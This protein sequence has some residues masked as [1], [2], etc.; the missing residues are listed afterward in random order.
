MGRQQD[1]E[2]NENGSDICGR[3][4][5]CSYAKLDREVAIP[6][7]Q[8]SRCQA[9]YIWCNSCVSATCIQQTARISLMTVCT[10]SQMNTTRCKHVD[11]RL[12]LHFTSYQNKTITSARLTVVPCAM[13]LLGLNALFP[14]NVCFIR[15]ALIL[16]TH[17]KITVQQLIIS[18]QCT[19]SY[20]LSCYSFQLLVTWWSGGYDIGLVTFGR[21]F[22]SQPG[23]F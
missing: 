16:V 3:P 1:W 17:S 18:V 13:L 10:T 11:I 20:K 2:L 7:S 9:G 15:S 23:Y 12:Q 14:L 21:R 8:T 5:K 6:L 4:R 22:N 19:M